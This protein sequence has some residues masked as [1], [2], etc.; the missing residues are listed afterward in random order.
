MDKLANKIAYGSPEWRKARSGARQGL[1][2]LGLLFLA[3]PLYEARDYISGLAAPR[4]VAPAT[5]G[6]PAPP[7]NS[8]TSA[9]NNLSRDI[10]FGVQAAAV[11]LMLGSQLL[12]VIG[13]HREGMDRAGLFAAM[14]TPFI[15][16]IYPSGSSGRGPGSR[17]TLATADGNFVLLLLALTPISVILSLWLTRKARPATGRRRRT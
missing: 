10:Y 11:L 3:Y 13:A 12:L 1:L 4:V 17:F 14:A 5:P 2:G 8:T 6:A 15:L 16:L 9:P 7:N